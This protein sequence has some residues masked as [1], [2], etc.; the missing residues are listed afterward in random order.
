[1]GVR[2]Q[3]TPAYERQWLWG[4]GLIRFH[5]N[6]VEQRIDTQS[7]TLSHPSAVDGYQPTLCGVVSSLRDMTN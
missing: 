6:L 7:I 5:Q 2:L 3:K 4:I 1:M